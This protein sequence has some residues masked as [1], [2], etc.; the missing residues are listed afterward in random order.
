M[1]YASRIVQK[2]VQFGNVITRGGV[3]MRKKTF[4]TFTG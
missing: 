1:K 2:K 4:E 3:Q